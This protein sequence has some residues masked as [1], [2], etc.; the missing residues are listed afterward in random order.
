MF[1][2][3]EY[4]THKNF[5]DVAIKVLGYVEKPDGIDLHVVWVLKGNLSFIV[6]PKDN[7][8]VKRSDFSKWSRYDIKRN[9]P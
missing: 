7:I 4:Y 2:A 6:A 1:R 8:F 9:G 5:I 3:S